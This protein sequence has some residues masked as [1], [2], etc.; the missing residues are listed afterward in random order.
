MVSGRGQGAERLPAR[1]AQQ[2]AGHL[3]EEHSPRVRGGGGAAHVP[4]GGER[5]ARLCPEPRAPGSPPGQTP[6][7]SQPA[8]SQL[9][10]SPSS[11]FKAEPPALMCMTKGL[12]AGQG[13]LP[14]TDTGCNITPGATGFGGTPKSS[15]PELDLLLLGGGSIVL[16]R[17]EGGGGPEGPPKGGSGKT[18]FRKNW[19]GEARDRLSLRRCL[20]CPGPD[21]DLSLFVS[22]TVGFHSPCWLEIWSVYIG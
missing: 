5:A 17:G 21:S 11:T 10:G 19:E 3:R 9:P 18:V 4:R 13:L 20:M 8:R 22:L 6:A 2:P 16:R 7:T 14:C 1:R 15:F 12:A